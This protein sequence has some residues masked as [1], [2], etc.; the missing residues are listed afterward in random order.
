M[1]YID[2]PNDASMSHRSMSTIKTTMF[3]IGNVKP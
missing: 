3:Y 1:Y 2:T